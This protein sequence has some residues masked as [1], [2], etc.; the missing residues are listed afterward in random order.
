MVNHVRTLLLNEPHDAMDGL[1][2]TRCPWAFPV[3]PSFYVLQL[4][5]KLSEIHARFLPQ[6]ELTDKVAAVNAAYSYLRR[7][8]IRE[9]LSVFDSRE[10]AT[11]QSKTDVD[12]SFFSSSSVFETVLAPTGV[13]RLDSVIT[14][15][16]PLRSYKV[17]GMAT[18]AVGI[19]AYAIHLEAVRLRHG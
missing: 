16:R 6:S 10:T 11:V 12:L 7:P 18:V 5:G 1:L 4:P 19:A 13:A 9:F 8:D 3:D 17:D 2:E 15:L 14:G